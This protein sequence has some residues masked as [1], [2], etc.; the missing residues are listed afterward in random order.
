[1]PNAARLFAA[2]GLAVL[3]WI[4]SDMIKPLV[5]FSVDFGWFNFVNA[6]I[7]ALVGWI[8]V[9]PRSGGGTTAAINNGITAAVVMAI[10]GLL[11][12]GTNEMVRLSFANRYDS[13]FE[14]IA[15]IFE[16]SLDY[17]MIL[18]DMQLIL[19]LLGGGIVAALVAEAVGRRWR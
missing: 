4:A 7:G 14:A 9:G 18:L 2:L 8:F 16:I 6:G 15:A 13:P 1:M 12:Q 3:G 10:V 11:V 17:G 5:P 19:T